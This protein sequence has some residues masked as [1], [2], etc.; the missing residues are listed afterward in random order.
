MIFDSDLCLSDPRPELLLCYG[1]GHC[2]ENESKIINPPY[3]SDKQIH[4]E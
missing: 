3:V 4:V 1:L 2:I